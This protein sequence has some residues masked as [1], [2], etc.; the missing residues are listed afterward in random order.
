MGIWSLALLTILFYLGLTGNFEPPNLIAS[1]LIALIIIGLLKPEK[2]PLNLK[3][4]PQMTFALIRYIARLIWDLI[5]GGIQVSCL[6]LNPKLPIRS[7]FLMIPS[8]TETDLGQALSAHAIS[9]APGELVV[10]IGTDGTFYT[11]C[12]DA[13][14]AAEYLDDAQRVRKELLEKIFP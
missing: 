8:K 7:G 12:L 1:I 2:R 9:L 13:T 3:Q 6:I 14:R 4:V 11:H 5:K 10:E